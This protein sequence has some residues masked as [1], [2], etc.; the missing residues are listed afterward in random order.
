MSTVA[1]IEDALLNLLTGLHGWAMIQSAGRKALPDPI[2]YPA[3]F[4]IW[5][6]D[7]DAATLPRPI[8]YVN[9]KVILL[10][11]NFASENLAAIDIYTLNDLVRGAIRGKT[12]GFPDIEPFTCKSRS[13]TDYD[14]S[15]GMIEYTHIYRTRLYNPIV[16]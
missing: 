12:L 14:D 5:D 11:Q 13:C 1:E 2:Y 8:D 4:I 6:G 16:V 7:E 3:C 9:F 10:V 15:D